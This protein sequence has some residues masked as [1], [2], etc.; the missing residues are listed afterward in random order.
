[1]HD[2][3]AMKR[4][5]EFSGMKTN[6]KFD[7]SKASSALQWPDVFSIADYFFLGRQ[8]A[9]GM[10]IKH[11][12]SFTIKSATFFWSFSK[13]IATCKNIEC[14]CEVRAKNH[15]T[16]REFCNTQT[17]TI[18]RCCVRLCVCSLKE[19]SAAFYSTDSMHAA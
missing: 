2:E 17:V 11:Y 5:L 3:H 19:R 12:S 13:L 14:M 18:K 4:Q 15:H 6:K 9:Y 7:Q 1:M 8:G 10:N 16:V